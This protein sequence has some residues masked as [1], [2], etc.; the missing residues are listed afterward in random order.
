MTDNNTILYNDSVE[1][2]RIESD[3]LMRN[4]TDILSSQIAIF[5]Y[6]NEK[7]LVTIPISI[8][9]DLLSD[10]FSKET[11]FYIEKNWQPKVKKFNESIQSA[12][13]A[14]PGF[15]AKSAKM[16]PLEKYGD[17]NEM[18]KKY[19]LMSIEEREEI[20]DKSIEG[21][22]ELQSKKTV[23]DIDSIVQMVD[24]I[25]NTFYANYANLD[26]TLSSENVKNNLHGIFVKTECSIIIIRRST[27]YRQGHIQSTT[28]IKDFSGL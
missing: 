24:V 25:A 7:K 4:L 6:N 8:L 27:G 16:S 26:D 9:E 18:M 11:V 21:L 1:L 20:L 14:K 3:E 12:K 10:S 17:T 2:L 22:H 28:S 5:R 15:S 13:A 19:N 23:I